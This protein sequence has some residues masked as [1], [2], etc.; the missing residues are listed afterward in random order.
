MI[1]A[2]TGLITVML[3]ALGAW[4]LWQSR[5]AEPVDEARRIWNR[6]IKR[7]DRQGL[8]PLAHEGPQDFAARATSLSPA[9]APRIRDLARAYVAVRYAERADLEPLRRAEKNLRRR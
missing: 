1:L 5:S 3:S 4:L 8:G 7:L 2:L 6:A 9:M